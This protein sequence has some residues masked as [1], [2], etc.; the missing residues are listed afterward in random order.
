MRYRDVTETYSIQTAPLYLH[1]SGAAITHCALNTH[2][3]K[4]AVV[5]YFMSL[6]LVHINM[7]F[8]CLSCSNTTLYV[9]QYVQKSCICNNT[10]NM[11][12][13]CIRI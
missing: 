6:G 3:T 7:F 10:Q 2:F 8:G 1:T 12:L 4:C 9:S 5:I 13:I 11:C